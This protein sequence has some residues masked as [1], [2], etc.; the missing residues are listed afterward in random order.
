MFMPV[1]G[2]KP[3]PR[4]GRSH[5]LAPCFQIPVVAIQ[6]L[7]FQQSRLARAR[8]RRS[9]NGGQPFE[10]GHPEAGSRHYIDAAGSA[11]G[12]WGDILGQ[13]A[14]R[15][16]RPRKAFLHVRL[17][18]D[19]FSYSCSGKYFHKTI[20]KKGRAPPATPRKKSRKKKTLTDAPLTLQGSKDATLHLPPHQGP[21]PAPPP[22]H[23]SI[24]SF[25]LPGRLSVLKGIRHSPI[26][27]SSQ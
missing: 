13:T 1:R 7:A 16:Q 10:A 5:V 17:S 11:E 22:P 6:V 23:S 3:V 18:R 9:V 26:I 4:F 12:N 2:W 21:V 20:D 14:R 25:G 8:N 24:L 15:V 19:Y 27:S